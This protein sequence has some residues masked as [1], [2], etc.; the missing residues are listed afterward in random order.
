VQ[1]DARRLDEKE[2]PMENMNVKAAPAVQ[3]TPEVKMVFTHDQIAKR[4][5][6]IWERKNRAK[7]QC[8]QNWREAEVELRRTAG[9]WQPSGTLRF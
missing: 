4:A 2:V 1:A 6:G 5:Y 9:D 8:A 3:S 7:G